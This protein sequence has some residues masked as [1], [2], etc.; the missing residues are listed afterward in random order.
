V[1]DSYLNTYVCKIN[2]SKQMK[3][4]PIRLI[5]QKLTKLELPLAIKVQWNNWSTNRQQRIIRAI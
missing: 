4:E 5:P 1:E 3:A 2:S